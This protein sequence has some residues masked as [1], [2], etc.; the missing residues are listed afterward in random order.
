MESTAALEAQLLDQ[1]DDG[2]TVRQL[3]KFLR[4]KLPEISLET[5]GSELS[6]S[7]DVQMSQ[8]R[9]VDEIRAPITTPVVTTKGPQ[10]TKN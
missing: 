8:K 9:I 7:T 1:K 10:L 5:S 2:L 3:N 6:A 4:V